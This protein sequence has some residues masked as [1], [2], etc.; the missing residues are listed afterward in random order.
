MFTPALF[1]RKEGAMQEVKNADGKRVCDV[2]P[3]TRTVVIKKK[4][5][6]TVIQFTDNGE[7]HITSK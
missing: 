7:C 4:D 2:D 6:K 3:R 1:V 5:C